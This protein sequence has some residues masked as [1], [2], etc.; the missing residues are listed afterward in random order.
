MS[1]N[2]FIKIITI[3][4]LIIIALVLYSHFLGTKGLNIREYAVKNKKISPNFEGFKIVHFSDLHYGSTVKEKE[5]TKLV[6]SINALKPDLVIFTGDLIEETY[7]MSEKE[8][9]E[10]SKS[11]NNITAKIGK[12]YVDGNH[13]INKAYELVMKDSGFINMNNKNDLI[14]NEGT[15]PII[16]VGLDDYLLKKTDINEAFNYENENNYYTILLV[17]EPDLADQ[18]KDKNVDLMLSGHSHNGQV[19]LPFL[20]AIITIEGSKKYYDEKYILDNTELYIS[21][22]I[23]TSSAP[24]R[25]LVK[26]SFNFYRLYK[27]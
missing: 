13:D 16:L 24:F 17:H 7:Y 25:F 18:I 26:P 11:L 6:E 14:Y 15:T 20:G 8:Q 9:K 5:M 2:V 27:K 4:L 12:Y 1:N 3:L 21:G 10:L 22:G 23:G 19:R